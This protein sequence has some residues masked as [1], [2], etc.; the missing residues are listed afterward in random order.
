MHK[1]LIDLRPNIVY[2]LL[3]Q[4]F[5]KQKE[6]KVRRGVQPSF[7]KG[8]I[9]GGVTA[10]ININEENGKSFVTINFNATRIYVLA[11]LISVISY[12]AVFLFWSLEFFFIVT[13]FAASALF[14]IPREI[15]EKEESFKEKVKAVLLVAR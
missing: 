15:K 12:V 3:V 11:L 8:T 6:I 9:E 2:D 1:E 14:I 4:Y 7:I 13:F 10:E 5:Q